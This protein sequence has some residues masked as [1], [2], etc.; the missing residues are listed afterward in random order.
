MGCWTENCVFTHYPIMYGQ[1]VFMFVIKKHYFESAFKPHS[2]AWTHN[3]REVWQK[4]SWAGWG[5]YND[6]GWIEELDRKTF[7]DTY[8]KYLSENAEDRDRP[9]YRSYFVHR[10]VMEAIIEREK[11][12]PFN[13]HDVPE[14]E[15]GFAGMEIEADGTITKK[16]PKVPDHVEYVQALMRLAIE[17]RIDLNAGIEFKGAQDIPDNSEW[18]FLLDI[19]KKQPAIQKKHMRAFD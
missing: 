12:K 17:L 11:P 10:N 6:Y 9:D 1:P 13:I 3:D 5:T 7:S 2:Y 18:K 15:W 8:E 14:L 19:M 4:L 16:P